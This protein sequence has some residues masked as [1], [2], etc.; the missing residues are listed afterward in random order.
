VLD[1]SLLSPGRQAESK[2][3]KGRKSEGKRQKAKG[4]RQKAEG[5][6]SNLPE[7]PLICRDYHISSGDHAQRKQVSHCIMA[8]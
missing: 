5:N 4:R 2:R 1:A 6:I 3:Q 8:A 7:V